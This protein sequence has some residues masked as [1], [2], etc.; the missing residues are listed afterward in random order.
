L[1]GR[2]HQPDVLLSCCERGSKLQ[3]SLLYQLKRQFVPATDSQHLSATYPNLARG[4]VEAADVFR[5]A[6]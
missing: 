6:D 1:E 2:N 5:V 4:L 3:E